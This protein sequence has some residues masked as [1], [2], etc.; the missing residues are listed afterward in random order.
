MRMFGRLRETHPRL[1][2]AASQAWYESDHTGDYEGQ[3]FSTILHFD[4]ST[5]KC[6]RCGKKQYRE[7]IT[8]RMLVGGNTGQLRTHWRIDCDSPACG[9][10]MSNYRQL[11]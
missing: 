9:S 8:D 6:P 11:W 4:E 5:G 1:G 2:L 3:Q 10:G 7:R